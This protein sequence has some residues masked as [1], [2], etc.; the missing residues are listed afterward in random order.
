MTETTRQGPTVSVVTPVFDPDPDHLAACL[1]SVER[2]TMRRV[3]HVLVDD[4]STRA[5]VAEIL[6]SAAA[7]PHVRLLRRREQGGIVAA[8]NEGLGAATGEFVAFLDHDDMLHVDAIECMIA[9]TAGGGVDVVYSDHDFLDVTGEHLGPCLKPQWSPERLRNQN[10]VT[11]FVMARRALVGEVGGL[12]V[13]F[14]GAQDHDLMLRLGER[15]RQIVHVPEILYHWRQAPSSVAAGVDAKPWAFDAG[16]RAVTEHCERIGL[17]A[18]VEFTD[19]EGIYRVRRRAPGPEPLV[20][21]LVPTRGSSGK[22]WGVNRCYVVEALRSVAD[23]STYQNLEFVVIVD[24]DTPN[25]VIASLRDLFGD[26]LTLVEHHG[27]FNFSTKMNE[28]AAAASGD[29]LLFLNDDTELIEPDS[30]T[31]LVGIVNGPAEGLDGCSGRVG[32]AGAKLLFDDGTLQHGGHVYFH[33]P[34]HALTGWPG[35]SPGPAP[36][37]PL[38]VERECSGVTAAV[39][40]VSTEVFD[41]VGGFPEALPLNYNDVDFS[42]RIRAAGHRIIWTPHATWHHFESRTRVGDVLPEETAYVEQRW[43]YE[44]RNDPYYNPRFAPLWFDWLEWPLED[45]P[46][47]G[48]GA[49]RPETLFDRLRAK[50]GRPRAGV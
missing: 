9:A 25:P 47:V 35:D 5:G 10:Y 29:F 3:E 15:A 1:A 49:E 38:A 8:T 42:L 4:G 12:R 50:L 26:R 48:H 17:D 23:R 6:E 21:V 45:L 31:T 24:D 39:A 13:G 28:G 19:R 37:H 44:L 32:M 22:V 40:L 11:H 14:D 36:L 18:D 27:A 33:G 20:S 30:I 46:W 7:R 16:V 41:D 43:A 2:Q 34:H